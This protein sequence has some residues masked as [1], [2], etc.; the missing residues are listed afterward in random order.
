V[1]NGPMAAKKKP[2]PK[3]TPSKKKVAPKK[4]P[5]K[6][7]AAVKR[8]VK[9]APARRVAAKKSSPRKTTKPKVAARRPPMHVYVSH[10]E[11]YEGDAE[12]SEAFEV[13]KSFDRDGSGSIDR[14]E[15]ARLL[16]ALGQGITEEELNVALDVVD[17]NHSGRI[18]WPEFLTWWTA[19]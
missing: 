10:P 14:G 3:K 8:P 2:A 9:K 17:S 7:K 18:S 11:L 5:R 4:S 12:H 6:I 19:G 1:L 16:E 13:F 15:F